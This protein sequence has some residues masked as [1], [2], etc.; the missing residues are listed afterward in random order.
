MNILLAVPAD[1]LLL[2]S[3]DTPFGDPKRSFTQTLRINIVKGSIKPRGIMLHKIFESIRKFGK[4][5]K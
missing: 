2:S 3:Q 4:H 1:R 5:D